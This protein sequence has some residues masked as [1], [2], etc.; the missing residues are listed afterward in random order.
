MT[1][2]RIHS[3]RIPLA[4]VQPRPL[5]DVKMTSHRRRLANAV[6]PV[7]PVLPAPLQKFQVTALS[8]SSTRMPV[9]RSRRLMKFAIPEPLQCFQVTPARNV[10]ANLFVPFH[11]VGPGP[12]QEF[13]GRD[14]VLHLKFFAE[15]FNTI[16]PGAKQ[17]RVHHRESRAQL[18][19]TS[20]GPWVSAADPAP[21]CERRPPPPR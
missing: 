3:I 13:N 7:A 21:P 8:R 2:R 12:F 10:A 17:A 14:E 18:A 16:S 11:P 5:I 9:P 1:R 4:A 15:P 20:R 6:V 19:Q